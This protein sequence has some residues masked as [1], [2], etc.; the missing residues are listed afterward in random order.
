[1]RL[2][3]TETDIGGSTHAAAPFFLTFG[4]AAKWQNMDFLGG[5]KKAVVSTAA[6]ENNTDISAVLSPQ[7]SS[8]C[9]LF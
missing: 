5:N 1:M 4:E 6:V 3:K 7:I 8:L 2:A 9:V